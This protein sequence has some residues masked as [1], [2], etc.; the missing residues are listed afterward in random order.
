MEIKDWILLIIPIVCNRI[1]LY[2]F[3]K[4]L[5]EKIESVKI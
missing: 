1:I 5:S 2:I 4:Y 3:Q